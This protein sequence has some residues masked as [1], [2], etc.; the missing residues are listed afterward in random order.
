[1]KDGTE[2]EEWLKRTI[3]ACGCI[4]QQSVREKHNQDKT[5]EV[6]TEYSLRCVH[7]LSILEKFVLLHRNPY[8]NKCAQKKEHELVTPLKH[9]ASALIPFMQFKFLKVVQ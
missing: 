3:T 6:P 7:H 1:M 5:N 8:H 2:R 4:C 9:Q